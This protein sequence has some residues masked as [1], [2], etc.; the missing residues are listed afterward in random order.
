MQVFDSGNFGH[1]P[2]R[3]E[4]SYSLRTSSGMRKKQRQCANNNSR[5]FKLVNLSKTKIKNIDQNYRQYKEHNI[6][7]CL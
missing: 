5:N 4:S 2:R 1:G 7:E 3:P 6:V